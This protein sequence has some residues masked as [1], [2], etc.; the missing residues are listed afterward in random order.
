M[1]FRSPLLLL[2]L[3]AVP[4]SLGVYWLAQQRKKRYAVRF[5]GVATLAS[6]VEAEPQWRRHL[7]PALFAIAL[8]ALALALAR[9]EKTVAVPVQQ[10]SVVLVTDVS[11][12]MQATDVEPSRLDA[13]K[14]AARSFLDRVPGRL[15]IGLVGFSSAPST[16]QRPTRNY[17]EVG[18]LVD[19]LVADGATATGDALAAALAMVAQQKPGAR[20]PAALLLL[21]PIPR[22]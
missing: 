5:P 11:R 19:G 10:A 12:S 2:C 3:A 13:A 22:A 20:P 8:T 18:A 4:A 15:K 9:P 21:R 7:P 6:L 1:S 17:Q 14:K 16:V